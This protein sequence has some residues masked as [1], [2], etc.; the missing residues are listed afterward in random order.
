MGSP[1]V[2]PA[3]LSG[4]GRPVP[5]GENSLEYLLDVIKKYDES[6]VG[7]EPLVPYQR[8]DIKPDQM[9]R[10]PIPKIPRTP[11][12]SSPASKHKSSLRSHAFSS[13]ATPMTPQPISRQSE[14][15]DDDDDDE[16]FDNSLERTVHTPMSMQSGVYNSRLA[17]HFYKD[18]SVWLYNGVKGTPRR[19]PSWTPARTPGRTPGINTTARSIV[20]SHIR[21]LV[22]RL[23]MRLG[24]V[25]HN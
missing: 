22:T 17:S 16:N 18:F 4:F 14:Y 19:A 9:A 23:L 12:R 7:R 20:S 8:D 5:G 13:Y 24:F 10:T 25:G 6:T 3:H 1:L 2:L 11:Y 21:H 15:F